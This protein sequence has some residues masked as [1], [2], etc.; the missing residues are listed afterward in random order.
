[1]P[2]SIYRYP[3]GKS[4]VYHLIVARFPEKYKEF[5]S[6]LVGGGGLFFNIPISKKRWI[7][8]IN[9]NLMSVYFALRDRPNDFIKKCK[10]IETEKKGE[11]RRPSRKNGRILYNARLG[12]VFDSFVKDDKIDP[13][14]RYFF[15]NRTGWAG[16]VN[17]KLPSRFYY[18]NPEGWGIINSNRLE[19][20][21][22][23]MKGV[24]ITCLDCRVLLSR[25]GNDVLVYLDP[26]YVKNSYLSKTSQLYENNFKKKDHELLA[27]AVHECKH[28]IIMSYDD[29]KDGLIRS[30]YSDFNIYNEEWKYSGTSSA[31]GQ[32]NKKKIGKEL[33]ITNYSSIQQTV[34]I[35]ED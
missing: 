26:P 21:A 7:N 33:I 30:L 3:G 1:M 32:S 29:D 23:I 12:E 8:D 19:D 5:R 22:K 35:F 34:D 9:T 4:K 10:E 16:R 31:T 14:L 27:E 20:A 13:A 28:K 15:L 11:P 18:S 6:A 17:Y 2:R 24:E 25:P